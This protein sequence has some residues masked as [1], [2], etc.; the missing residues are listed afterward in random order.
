LQRSRDVF[1]SFP[2]QLHYYSHDKVPKAS[3]GVIMYEQAYLQLQSL[4]DVFLINRVAV[5]RGVVSGQGLFD[6]AMEMLDIAIMF[7][8]KRDELMMFSAGFDWI[9]SLLNSISSFQR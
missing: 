9:V 6:V 1:A 8:M 7:W 3:A 2:S 5:A 4:Q